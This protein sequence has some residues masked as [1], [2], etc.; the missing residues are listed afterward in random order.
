VVL[1]SYLNTEF[2][3]LVMKRPVNNLADLKGKKIWGSGKKAEV[4]KSLGAVPVGLASPE[5]YP[6]FQRGIIDGLLQS[7]ADTINWNTYEIATQILD[8]R[9]NLATIPHAFNPKTFK[10][11]PPDLQKVM[12]TMLQLLA[13]ENANH[14]RWSTEKAI[15]K[16][17]Q[18]GNMVA[19]LT[20]DEKQKWE[21]K[22]SPMW[23]KY[24]E[25]TE[26]KG[27]PG[28][29]CVADLRKAAAKYADWTPAQIREKMIKDPFP[30]LIDGM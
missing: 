15:E 19:K 8:C 21:E 28:K 1:G 24:I 25:E 9:L 22:L 27:L 16:N 17:K 3:N 10:N 2:N 5:I 6:S 23:E 30:G 4:L 13:W 11:L 20:P 18:K 7:T 14:Y 12:Y 29:E 26:A